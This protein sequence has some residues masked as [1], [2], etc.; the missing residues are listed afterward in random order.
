MIRP[1]SRIRLHTPF[2]FSLNLNIDPVWVSNSS[3]K[4]CS[5]KIFCHLERNVLRTPLLQLALI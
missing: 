5:N 2:L 1:L 4:L 3:D